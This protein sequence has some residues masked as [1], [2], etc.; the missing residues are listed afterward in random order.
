M[1]DTSLLGGVNKSSV[2]K[3]QRIQNSAAKL[4]FRRRKYEHVSPLMFELHWLPMS[5]RIDFRILVFVFNSLTGNCPEY[6]DD[7]IEEYLP[8][9]SL[10]SQSKRLLKVKRYRNSYGK[11]AFSNYAPVLWNSLPSIV[12][13]FRF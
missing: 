12:K 10:R 11:R 8:S 2:L 5:A 1:F 6:I 7:C 4:I 13:D 9:R 3:L